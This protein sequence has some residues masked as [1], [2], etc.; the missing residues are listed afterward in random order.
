METTWNAEQGPFAIIPE[1]PLLE[2]QMT[3]DTPL[4]LSLRLYYSAILMRGA[5]NSDTIFKHLA[6]LWR[7]IPE[8]FQPEYPAILGPLG[9]KIAI[10]EVLTSLHMDTGSMK[11]GVFGQK[12]KEHC[13]SWY[14][15][16]KLLLEYFDGNPVNIFT[17]VEEFEEAYVRVAK[18]AKKSGIKGMRR[19]IFSLLTLWLQQRELIHMFRAPLPIDIHALRILAHTGIIT[20]PEAAPFVPWDRGIS[21]KTGQPL[22]PFP[23]HYTG[24]LC[25]RITDAL[26]TEITKW[27]QRIL[28]EYD[29]ATQPI[30]RGLWTL[31]RMYCKSHPQ[32]TTSQ[33]NGFRER[34][35][36]DHYTWKKFEPCDFCLSQIS[37]HCT[38]VIPAGPYYKVGRLFLD[39]NRE[40]PNHNTFLFMDVL[41]GI[42]YYLARFRPS[43]KKPKTLPA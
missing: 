17:G 37:G 24:R 12:L 25:V 9:I 23:A 5:V 15:N 43:R 41:S 30:N 36:M 13:M 38:L 20:F 18:T 27:S 11:T 1:L 29:I 2:D 16:S 32:S 40:L 21:K 7:E 22:P 39:I 19:K 4:L 34:E 10:Q 31:S 8:L 28:T 26:V 42:D 6:I 3:A 35:F 33:K 14:M